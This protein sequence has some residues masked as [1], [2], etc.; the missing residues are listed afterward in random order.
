MDD[1]QQ[2]HLRYWEEASQN[3]RLICHLFDKPRDKAWRR[4]VVLEEDFQAPTRSEIDLFTNIGFAGRCLDSRELRWST[5]PN[6]IVPSI[7]AASTV[8]TD[9]LFFDNL[10]RVVDVFAESIEYVSNG[11]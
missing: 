11:C 4:T 5:K 7:H 1:G 9:D 6:S 10:V 2:R 3:R 8:I